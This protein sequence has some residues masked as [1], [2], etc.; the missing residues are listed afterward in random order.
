[1]K[2]KSTR[3]VTILSAFMALIF[4]LVSANIFVVAVF[5]Y[6]INS[7]TNIKNEAA[8]I[9]RY[10]R[11]IYAQRG[12]IKD[13]NG[14][15]FA[16]DADAYTL[17]AN[18]DKTRI[19][20]KGNPAH[21]NDVDMAAPIIA[22]VIQKDEASVRSILNSDSKQVE[23]GIEGRAITHDQMKTLSESGI[24]G[25][26]FT[27]VRVRNN[28]DMLTVSKLLGTASFNEKTQRIEGDMG[29]EALYND[30]LAGENGYES[31][32]MDRDGYRLQ[33]EELI[34]REP[35]NGKD[36]YLTLDASI[37]R[38]LTESLMGIVQDPNVQAQNAWGIVMEAKTGKIL[39]WSEYPGFDP[40]SEGNTYI[41]AVN[42]SLFEP[43]STMKT[44]SVAAAIDQGVW[45]DAET[46]DSGPFYVGN[47]GN[48][49][50]RLSSSNG[51]IHT[52]TNANNVDYGTMRYD[53][54]YAMSS[55]V[56]ISELMTRKLDYD[57]YM[58]YLRQL[59]FFTPLDIDGMV[60]EAGFSG[61]EDPS[62]ITTIT[63]AFGQGISVTM[64][65]MAQAYTPLMTDGTLKKPYIIDKIVDQDS[66]EV[67][68]QGKTQ[69]MGN[70]FKPETASHMRD[71]MNMVVKDGSAMRFNIPET[72]VIGKTGTAQIAEGGGY[73]PTDYIFSSVLGFPYED[74]EIIVYTAYRAKYG[75]NINYSA[76]HTNKIVK[77]AVT[78]QSLSKE[79]GNEVIQEVEAQE[80]PNVLNEN[81]DTVVT[82]LTG[83]GYAVHRLGDG[84]V[85]Q[86]QYPAP[87]V[88]F[89]TGEKVLI[90]TGGAHVT[91]PDFTGWT[92]KEMRG[93]SEV[94]AIPIDIQGSGFV[95]TQS[96][97]PG[98]VHPRTEPI[99][100]QLK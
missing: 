46:F 23:F 48:R 76:E 30:K 70:V 25:L 1:M 57:I 24:P 100:V 74:P 18:I 13:R 41:D 38:Q 73:H 96:I 72:D 44:F 4:L 37:Q 35:H 92:L 17:Y 89:I 67:S 10:E 85:V 11:D 87:G 86:R 84:S 32:L 9:Q 28:P 71:L 77:T 75:H 7:G 97:P 81:A 69:I 88:Q 14:N 95:D 80:L 40:N 65:Q 79:T 82:E 54:G 55:N 42:Q 21:V 66:N 33:T 47:N 26:G 51:S 91:L 49:A 53:Y 60:G 16:Q 94:T 93:F 39:G 12:H 20:G 6:H 36:I 27:P 59:K 62:P 63:S 29:L 68:Y 3:K 99:S 98:T 83:H 22:E 58:D 52:I 64:A 61:A 50:V 8:G 5:G 78:A 43:G 19:D 2:R 31:Y 90:D 45:N 56:M 15:I 34:R